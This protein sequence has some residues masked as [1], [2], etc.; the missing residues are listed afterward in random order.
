[1]G[2]DTAAAVAKLRSLTAKFDNKVRSTTPYYSRLCTIIPSDGY[3]EE[4]GLL[5]AVPQVREWLAERKFHSVRAAK[6]TI[7]N[8]HW[9]SGIA[10]EKTR[11][12]DDRMGIYVPMFE[13]L[14][15]RAVRHPDKLLLGTLVANAETTVCLDGQFFFD[16]DHLWGDSGSQDNDLSRDIVDP[17]APTV[18]EFKAALNAALIQMMSFKD[19]FGEFLHDDAVIGAASGMELLVQV[20]LKY[21]EVAI[22]ATT[23]G[24]MVNNGETNVVIADALVAATPHMTGNKFDLYRTDT[25]VKPYIFQAREPL[26]RAMK[27]MEDMEFKDVK[28]MTEARYNLGYGAWWNAVR[29]TFI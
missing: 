14:G 26:S 4:Y 28:F 21:R 20:P 17:A 19:D 22:K 13:N 3:D 7:E 6:F 18:D 9:E 24:I 27:G 25:P 15:V 2:L 29:V 12:R 5:G 11:I 10:V 16:T 23:S 8:K 1:M